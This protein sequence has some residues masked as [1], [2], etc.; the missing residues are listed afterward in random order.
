MPHV[1]QL[2]GRQRAPAF[3]LLSL[4]CWVAS[5]LS[6]PEHGMAAQNPAGAPADV[7]M[8]WTPPPNVIAYSACVLSNFSTQLKMY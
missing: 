7:G 6:W 5:L 2:A 8:V 4:P 3:V 1:T